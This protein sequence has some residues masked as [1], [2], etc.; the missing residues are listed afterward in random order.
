MSLAKIAGWL[1]RT[2]DPISNCLYKIGVLILAAMMCLTAVDVLMRYAFNS[3]IM[4]AFDITEYMMVLLVA[5]TL[6]YCSLKKRLVKV[7]L[8]SQYFPVRIRAII[9]SFTSLIGLAIFALITW[10]TVIYVKV[11][12]ETHVS[13]LVLHI[14][15]YPFIALLA[16][17]FFCFIITLLADFL[18]NVSK[19]ITKIDF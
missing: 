6:A 14:P 13:S 18:E 3:P 5:F 8:L 12:Y 17:S 11:Q 9:D 4:G 19:V 2:I 15:R 1:Y 7:D 16:F 10:Q